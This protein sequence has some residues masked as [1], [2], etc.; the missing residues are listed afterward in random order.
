MAI[1]GVFFPKGFWCMQSSRA[2][3]CDDD[4]EVQ[5]A[6]CFQLFSVGVPLAGVPV[7]Y[8]RASMSWKVSMSRAAAGAKKKYPRTGTDTWYSYRTSTVQY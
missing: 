2:V 4:D 7:Q 5:R 6:A 8:G 3:L 1:F